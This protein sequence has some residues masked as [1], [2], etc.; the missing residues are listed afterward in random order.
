MS[1]FGRAKSPL[2]GF[3]F[4]LLIA[5]LLI[6]TGGYFLLRTHKEQAALTPAQVAAVQDVVR[7]YVRGHPEVVNEA[8]KTILDQRRA[9]EEEHRKLNI[10]ALAKELNQD[11]DLPVGNA[12]GDVTVVEFFDYACP[13][14]KAMA[15]KLQILINDDKKVRFVFKDFP[16]LGSISDFAAHAALASRN[17]D[18]YLPFHFALMDSQGHLSQDIVFAIAKS[19]GIDVKRLKQDMAAPELDQIIARNKKL[20]E[21]LNIDGTPDFIVGE[22]VIPGAVDVS[23]IKDLIKKER[24][25]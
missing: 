11:P 10:R 23:Y 13:Y 22:T 19:V 8:L 1:S 2:R 17:Q 21:G 24:G 25:G 4:G 12:D 20:A 16:V 18:K 3:L 6:A 9:A 5:I 15:P 7:D 14:C